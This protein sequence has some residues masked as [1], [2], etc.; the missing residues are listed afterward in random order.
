MPRIAHDAVVG[1]VRT[2]LA[3]DGRLA[4]EPDR[5]HRSL[6]D[7]IPAEDRAIEL[8]VRASELEIPEL[9]SAGRPQEA[10]DRLMD[11]GGFRQDVASWIVRTWSQGLLLQSPAAT[12]ASGSGT[13]S[14]NQS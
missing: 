14:P 6:L 11:R 7:L 3:H 13:S 4:R 12:K 2:A 8:L 10:Y 5:L 9:L 1:A